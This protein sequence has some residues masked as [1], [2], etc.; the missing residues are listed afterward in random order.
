MRVVSTIVRQSIFATE[1]KID[2]ENYIEVDSIGEM[3]CKVLNVLWER[4]RAMTVKE[5]TEDVNRIFCTDWSYEDIRQFVKFLI[6]ADYVERRGI[7]M[8]SRYAALAAE[9]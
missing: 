5:L 6:A 2:M 7:G 4:N 3:P 1:R 8:M 9:A